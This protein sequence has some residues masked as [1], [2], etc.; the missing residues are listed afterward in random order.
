MK[1]SVVVIDYK[2]KIY[3][4][5]ALRSIKNQ[6]GIDLND[7]ELVVVKYYEDE[8]IDNYIKENFP[9]YK[10]I[11]L[12]LN[13][14]NH[15]VGRTLSEGI[16]NASNNLIFLLEDDDL[17]RKNKIKTILE[18]IKKKKL[19]EK[20]IN[21]LIHNNWINIDQNK[22]LTYKKIRYK[23]LN[24]L[25]LKTIEYKKN[26]ITFWHNTSSMTIYLKDNY[27]KNKLLEFLKD[28]K[29]SPDS[30]IVAFFLNYG[31]VYNISDILTLYRQS[32]NSTSRTPGLKINLDFLYDII[33]TC[34]RIQKN[35]GKIFS[36][37]LNYRIYLNLKYS[38]DF[39]IYLLDAYNSLKYF[40]IVKILFYLFY[41]IR[42]IYLLEKML[43]NL[44]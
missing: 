32:I 33:R 23:Y 31:K 42:K 11:N 9:N 28:I 7:L 22:N 21:F 20:N 17:F 36:V 39:P 16:K 1:F 15:W 44:L 14:P 10:I 2:R 43:N 8:K 25:I 37:S 19:I 30:T 29:R 24:K 13:D 41:K 40:N 27:N 12:D 18:F 6:E 5:D 26:K 4:L 3:I 34:N 35:K 38:Y